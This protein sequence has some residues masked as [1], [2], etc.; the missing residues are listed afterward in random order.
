M[1]PML[2]LP[3]S[4]HSFVHVCPG[5]S[6]SSVTGSGSKV[7]PKVTGGFEIAHVSFKPSKFF[8]S[9]LQNSKT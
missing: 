2:K 4:S 5:L 1:G 9:K 6:S 8:N 3:N 7:T